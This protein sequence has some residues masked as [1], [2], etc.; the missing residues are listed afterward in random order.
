MSAERERLHARLSEIAD[1]LIPMLDREL[2]AEEEKRAF[3]ISREGETLAKRLRSLNS[4]SSGG[5]A[6][7]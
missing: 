1:E 5:S 4:N 2:S 3:E 6:K 7:P